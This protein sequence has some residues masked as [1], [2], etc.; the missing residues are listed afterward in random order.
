ME[1]L[2]LRNSGKILEF[3]ENLENVLKK[4]EVQ[5]KFRKNCSSQKQIQKTFIQY[6]LKPEKFF[7]R[8]EEKFNSL[9]NYRGK[10]LDEF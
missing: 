9:K 2:E 8:F 4:T 1:T 6:I 10:I 3:K 7:K 5:N